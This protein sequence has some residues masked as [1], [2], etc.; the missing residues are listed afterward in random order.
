MRIAI[1]VAPETSPAS[2]AI[3][4]E[5]F[6]LVRDRV[7]ALHRVRSDLGMVTPVVLLSQDGR[8]VRLTDGRTAM[9]D[10]AI[11]ATNPPETV[12]LPDLDIDNRPMQP[13]PANLLSI[14]YWLAATHRAGGTIAASGAAIH[15]LAAAHLLDGAP[16]WAPSELAATFRARFAHVRGEDHSFVLDRGDILVSRGL[17]GDAE[18]IV[19]LVGR[20]LAPEMAGWLARRVGLATT[21]ITSLSDDPLIANAQVW[22]GLHYA[23]TPRLADLAAILAVSEQTLLRRFKARLDVTPR[24]YLRRLRITAACRQLEHSTR[25]IAQIA[26]LAG[27]DDPKAFREAFRD[28]TGMTATQYRERHRISPID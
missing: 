12:V 21:A 14:P 20:V 27:Y 5:M 25:S 19:R 10:G 11:D 4:Q 8:S 16:M 13:S 28:E 2:L 23:D 17:A 26:V 1:L 18:M 3:A 6:R 24:A 22:L 9:V 15:D 7:E